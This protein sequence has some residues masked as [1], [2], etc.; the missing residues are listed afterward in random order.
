[1]VAI[2]SVPPDYYKASLD[3]AVAQGWTTIQRGD[4]SGAALYCYTCKTF[5]TRRQYKFCPYGH[6]P[7]GDIAEYVFG[8]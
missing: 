7:M 6:G 3:L 4:G 2:K 5:T 1:M 8:I